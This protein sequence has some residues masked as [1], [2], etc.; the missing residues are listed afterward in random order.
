MTVKREALVDGELAD[1]DGAGLPDGVVG[2]EALV[3]VEAGGEGAQDV[4]D[5]LGEGGRDVAPDAAGADVGGGEA[6]AGDE[7]ENVEQLLA[8]AEGV[9]EHGVAHAGGVHDVGAEP[10]EV[11]GDALELGHDRRG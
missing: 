9:H 5:A 10:E 3:L 4:G 11:G 7:L 6:G 2:H 1:A 8:L